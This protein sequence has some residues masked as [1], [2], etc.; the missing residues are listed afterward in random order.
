MPR[1]NAG[2]LRIDASQ[3]AIDEI[4]MSMNAG[5]IRLSA[6]STALGGDLSINAGAIDLCVPDAAGLNLSVT[7]QLTFAHNLGVAR[8]CP[9]R[10]RLDPR[11]DRWRADDP[12]V[13]RRQCREPHPEP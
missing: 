7:D 2:D 4:D 10:I 5:R 8:S 9:V 11:R 1:S 3:G 13:D 6:G 12:T